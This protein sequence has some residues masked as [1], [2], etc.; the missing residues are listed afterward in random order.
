MWSPNGFHLCERWKWQLNKFLC[1]HGWI[2]RVLHSI[3][4]W[5]QH[6]SIRELGIEGND[7]EERACKMGKTAWKYLLKVLGEGK[8]ENFRIP[9]LSI[10]WHVFA[11]TCWVWH[12]EQEPQLGCPCVHFSQ[13]H[14]GPTL[15]LPCAGT[16][17]NVCVTT[18][19]PPPCRSVLSSQSLRC[20]QCP[21]PPQWGTNEG[22]WGE[23]AA[24]WMNIKT[25][26]ECYRVT[27]AFLKGYFFHH[28][29]GEWIWVRPWEGFEENGAMV[30]VRERFNSFISQLDSHKHESQGISVS[31]IS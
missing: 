3:G 9:L 14:P 26:Q 19:P 23:W 21:Q 27:R 20:H 12:F 4:C 22:K 5:L 10:K 29:I 24:P 6:P 25:F 1:C 15:P 2:C 17:G 28:K 7:N 31:C 8:G 11:W 30:L 13:C 18:S 16:R